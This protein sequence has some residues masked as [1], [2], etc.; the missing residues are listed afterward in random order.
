[1]L[2]DGVLGMVMRVWMTMLS[3]TKTGTIAVMIRILMLTRYEWAGRCMH[4]G[5]HTVAFVD[6]QGTCNMAITGHDDK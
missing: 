3:S 5:V 2:T 4:A 1:M 6:V